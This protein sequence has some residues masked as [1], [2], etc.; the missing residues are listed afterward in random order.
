[1]PMP[2]DVLVTYK[3][4]TKEMHYIPLNMM[5]GTKPAENNIPRT[6]HNEWKWVDPEYSFNI[7]KSVGDIKEIEIDPSM[8]LAD[9]SRTNNK[10][11][12]P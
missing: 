3:N 6:I 2:I 11:V 7:S 9:V 5:Y 10:I 8:R 12:V 1:M 4:G